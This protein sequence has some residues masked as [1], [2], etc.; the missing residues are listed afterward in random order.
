[1]QYPR[2]MPKGACR[3]QRKYQNFSPWD[4]RAPCYCSNTHFSLVP[5]QHS[6]EPSSF[7]LLR[8]T[9]PS[10]G[11]GVGGAATECHLAVPALGKNG[12]VG[13]RRVPQHLPSSPLPT[14]QDAVAHREGRWSHRQQDPALF[15]CPLQ[16]HFPMHWG[17]LGPGYLVATGTGTAVG[18][19][20]VIVAGALILTG[21]GEAWVALGLDAQGRWTCGMGGTEMTISA[22]S[23]GD[24]S[25]CGHLVPRASGVAGSRACP[26]GFAPG[27]GTATGLL[28]HQGSATSQVRGWKQPGP[29]PPQGTSTKKI[30][31]PK[32]HSARC[33]E[34]GM[35]RQ[36]GH[37]SPWH[38]NFLAGVVSSSFPS[39]SGGPA[40]RAMPGSLYP[41]LTQLE[42]Q[43][44]LQ[45]QYRGLAP[46]ALHEERGKIAPAA[47]QRELGTTLSL[48][49]D[50]T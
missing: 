27:N 38:S 35:D 29:P 47:T 19:K 22:R 18:A 26:R 48:D 21:A 1:M 43:R 44:R 14:Q 20:G 5:V 2:Y 42:S 23:D 10:V 36:H 32:H 16:G 50:A 45:L 6:P 28:S 37:L 11:T 40:Q 13:G 8:L 39:M 41:V 17:P 31:E 46:M 24:V 12:K 15:P 25:F 34:E 30:L 4:A 9:G 49:Q 7:P 3:R 33:P